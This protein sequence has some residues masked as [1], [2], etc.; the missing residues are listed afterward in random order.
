MISP[1]ILA[2][3]E[4]TK[5]L[6]PDKDADALG[7]TVDFRLATAA[8]GGFQFHSRFQNS[9]NDQRNKLGLYKGGF[10]VSNRFIEEKLGVL[11]TGNIEKTNR[12]S[13]HLSASYSVARERREGEAFAPITTDAV[14]FE[15]SLDTRKRYSFNVMLDYTSPTSKLLMN[16]FISRLDRN[17]VMREKRY[18]MSGSNKLRYFIDDREQ[19]IDI[20]TSAVGGEHKWS[21][22]KV[23]WRLSRSASMTRYPFNSEFEFEEVGAFNTGQ[24]PQIASPDDILNNA[25]NIVEDT[26]L[27]KGKC[28]PERSA[29]R[30]LSAQL[31][32]KWPY[33]ITSNIVG[34][35][36]A[37]TKFRNKLRQRDRD[38]LVRRLDSSNDD[39]AVHH[40]K[41]GAP[42]FEYE[43]MPGTS[44]PKMTNYLD[45]SF[46]AGDF[47]DGEYEFGVGLDD[48]EL[49]YFLDRYL[50]D[51][52][53]RFSLERDLDDYH[54]TDLLSAGYVMS[55]LNLGRFLML[56]PGFWRHRRFFGPGSSPIDPGGDDG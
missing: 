39:F 21:S 1:E 44:Y 46:D 14:R 32:L 10:I 34:N 29:E 3:I 18:D 23:D 13:D 42:G 56:M 37:G 27:R 50:M 43:R 5:A 47:L 45:P 30:D 6:T 38:Y 19:Q 41:Y 54:V 48:R 11:L 31:N 8:T 33:A 26:Y 22:L 53:F 51:N 52:V 2:S 20:L 16:N 17:Q 28:E 49:R 9:Y 15:H 36:K 24:I 12:D 4:V 55:E 40:S 25:Y 35:L 7:G